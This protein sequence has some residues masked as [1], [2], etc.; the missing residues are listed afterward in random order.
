M[1]F[2]RLKCSK[3]LHQLEDEIQDLTFDQTPLNILQRKIVENLG[4]ELRDITPRENQINEKSSYFLFDDDVFFT[5]GFIKAIL[6]LSCDLEKSFK[7]GLDRNHFNNRFILPHRKDGKHIF[8]FFYAHHGKIS[9]QVEI[10]PQE[11]YENII[12]IPSQVVHGGQLHYDICDTF[13]SRMASPF[14]Y[15]QANLALLLM[16]GVPSRKAL[17]EWFFS[18][19]A[20]GNSRAFYFLIKRMNRIGKGCKIHPTA[21]LEGAVLGDNVTIGAYSVIRMSAIESG[22]KIEDHVIVKYS[23]IGKDNYISHANQIIFCQTLDEVFLIH[24]PYQFSFFGRKSSA[25]AV[26]NCDVRLDQKT[27]SIPTD[28]GILDS[29]QPLL[30]V[31]YGHRSVIGGGNIIAAGRIIPNDFKKHSPSITL[32]FK[33]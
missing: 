26:I 20:T 25:M 15:L 7:C 11:T 29:K 4:H 13:I 31:A 23:L 3:R 1:I 9:E 16:K 19:F 24:G 32:D 17:P 8:N 18:K 2:Y 14:H 6:K 27:I 21:V 12:K 33:N 5:E 10:V 22:T 30:G 28:E